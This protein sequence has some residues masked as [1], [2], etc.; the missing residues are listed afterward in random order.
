MRKLL[1]VAILLG[2][3]AYVTVRAEGA[4]ALFS[5]PAGLC[6]VAHRSVT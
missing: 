2:L 3:V 6:H 5:T 1:L 4:T